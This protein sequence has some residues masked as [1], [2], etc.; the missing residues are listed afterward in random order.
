MRRSAPA[1]AGSRRRRAFSWSV[2]RGIDPASVIGR[3]LG[4][5]RVIRRLIGVVP[6][7]G[8]GLLLAAIAAGE[9]PDKT[10]RVCA[11]PNNLPFSNEKLEGFE[12]KLAELVAGDLGASPTFTW[13]PD[14]RGFIR[15][16]LRAGLCDVVMGVPNGYDLVRW[17]RPYYRSTYVFVSVRDGEFPVRSWDDPALRRARIGVVAATPPADALV[18]KGLIRNVVSYRLTID[19]TTEHPGEIVDDVA[20]GKIDVAI[21]WGPIAGYFAKKQSVRLDVVPV[22]ELPEVGIPFR[23]EISMGVRRG[24]VERQSQLDEV[25]ERKGGE[26]RQLLAEYGVPLVEGPLVRKPDEIRRGVPGERYQ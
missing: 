12:N 20:A 26:I 21:V 16:T 17:T 11:D 6:A 25:L 24:D 22:P 8:V 9:A 7:V 23:Y 3:R 4:A 15:N 5:G 2:M 19:Y 13:W 14:R 10:F 18:K 1:P